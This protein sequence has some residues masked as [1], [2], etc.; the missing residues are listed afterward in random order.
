MTYGCSQGAACNARYK[1]DPSC[2]T[3]D[4]HETIESYL[5]GRRIPK[6][7]PGF[8]QKYAVILNDGRVVGA[9]NDGAELD[10]YISEA[11][12]VKS[13]CE[14]F[15]ASEIGR[16]F[17]DFM[18]RSGYFRKSITGYG[19]KDSNKAIASSM[20][21]GLENVI[22]ADTKFLARLRNTLEGDYTWAHEHL[23]GLYDVRTE[24]DVDFLLSEFFNY[25]ALHSKGEKREKYLKLREGAWLRYKTGSNAM[26]DILSK[27]KSIDETVEEACLE[28]RERENPEEGQEEQKHSQDETG[29][30]SRSKESSNDEGAS[31]EN[32][33]DESPGDESREN[34]NEAA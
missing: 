4:N 24:K 19:S 17:V 8:M 28:D 9:A 5:S 12:E 31:Y 10:K 16:G 32:R 18:E 25:M 3:I 14:K 27:E 26:L 29:D 33:N 21:T 7:H 11:K 13:L 34:S 30:E 1:T 6:V 22:F 15:M 23:H 2:E 20:Q